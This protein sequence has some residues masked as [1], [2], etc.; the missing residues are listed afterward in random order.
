LRTLNYLGVSTDEHVLNTLLKAYM[1]KGNVDEVNYYDFCYDVDHSDDL[2][3]VGRDFNHSFAY[4]PKT[5][6]RITAIDIKK[7]VPND[8]DDILA[9]LR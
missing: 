1:D 5:Q 9:K 2:F 3:Q 8:V 6:P 7:E 4:Y